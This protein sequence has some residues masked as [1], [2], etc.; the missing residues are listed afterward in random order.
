MNS[1]YLLDAYN[2]Y[3]KSES[4]SIVQ[5]MM[6]KYYHT[7]DSWKPLIEDKQLQEI[8]LDIDWLLICH[9]FNILLWL[10]VSNSF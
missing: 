10:C 1:D 4:A 9:L 7:Y 6:M 8:L 5:L 3:I 2:V